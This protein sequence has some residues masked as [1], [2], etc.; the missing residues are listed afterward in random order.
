MSLLGQGTNMRS[1]FMAIPG[2]LLVNVSAVQS[3]APTRG[4]ERTGTIVK[5]VLATADEK[6]QGLLATITVKDGV[7]EVPVRITADTR[8]WISKGKLGDVA[9]PGDFKVGEPVSVWLKTEASGRV[10]TEQFM[11]F[12][13]GE[14]DLPPR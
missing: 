12:R 6:K 7:V 5:I 1:F 3:Q 10:K 11:S 2:L 8:L 9:K 4:P 14:P 13:P